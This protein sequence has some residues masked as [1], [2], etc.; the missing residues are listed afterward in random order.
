LPYFWVFWLFQ[1][2][3][4]DQNKRRNIIIIFLAGSIPVIIIGIFQ[5][6]FKLYGPFVFLNGLVTWYSREILPND[7]MTG[8]F[9]NTNYFGMWLN[10][11]W[12][13]SLIYTKEN[14]SKGIN[15]LIGIGFSISILVC[16][17]LTFS[18]NAWLGIVLSTVLVL[19]VK[20][21]K[22]LIPLLSLL[23]TPVLVGLGFLSNNFLI[24]LSQK[25]IPQIVFLQFENLG[26]EN[27][28]SFIRLKIWNSSLDY[29]SQKPLTGWGSSSFPVLFKIDTGADFFAH[30][31]NLPLEIALS[32]GIPTAI[33]I[34]ST[35]IYLIYYS[36]KILKSNKRNILLSYDKAWWSSTTV[37][38]VC[39]MFD[40]QYFDVR[41]G[42]TLWI[43]LG[44]LR[45]IL[46]EKVV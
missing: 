32:F 41:I 36:Q 38:F 44:G 24:G 16:T 14:F 21:L 8:L 25:L 26:V 15:R 20:S 4:F 37:I 33:L 7:G 29:I 39:H 13:F 30:T 45:N 2:F 3:S 34:T 18:R 11:I 31:H 23:I 28:Q 40:V 12:P 6:F 42:L 1:R 22:W 19:G 9:N 10:I 43:L 27:L 35:I 17:I 5:Y 46:R